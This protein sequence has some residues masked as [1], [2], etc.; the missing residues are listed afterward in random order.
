MGAFLSRP[1]E[2]T[3][4]TPSTP[5]SD[6]L[7]VT[8]IVTRK[9]A[10]KINAVPRLT[11]VSIE[12]STA[13][14]HHLLDLPPEIRNR[15]YTFAF[16]AN[17]KPS[18]L[19]SSTYS[20]GSRFSTQIRDL[21]SFSLP[22]LTQVSR[23]LRLE[24]LPVFFNI[25]RFDVYIDSN[26]TDRAM[27]RVGLP[28]HTSVNQRKHTGVLGMKRHLKHRLHSFKSSALFR[29]V[30]FNVRT[31]GIWTKDERDIYSTSVFVRVRFNGSTGVQINSWEG[32]DIV[33]SAW[34]LFGQEDVD[35]TVKEVRVAAEGME[36]RDHF[37][38]FT[39]RD[40]EL[41]ANAFRFTG[42]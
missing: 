14:F 40:L 38:G 42:E 32:E 41:L 19:S 27:A 35:A 3:A 16:A 13:Q 8:A 23:Q 20:T 17:A 29:D 1:A 31:T 11:K 33:Q 26:F 7:P 39:I 9:P 10:S 22:P 36:K 24:S 5:T 6:T 37:K 4:R 2:A 18:A 30:T 28:F 34:G 21:A 12:E 25:S 15:I